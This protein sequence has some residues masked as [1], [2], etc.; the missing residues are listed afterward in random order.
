LAIYGDL[1]IRFT[2]ILLP[3]QSI[4]LAILPPRMKS[5]H[6]DGDLLEKIKIVSVI[7]S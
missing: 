4:G 7:S 5:V 3:Y 2:I 6:L 1:T